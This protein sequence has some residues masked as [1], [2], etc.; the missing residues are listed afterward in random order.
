M[1]LKL[2][3]IDAFTDR[4]FGGNP[5]AVCPLN[6][7]LE[8]RV[9]QAIAEENNLAE[10]AFFLPAKEGYGLRWFTPVT[11]VNLCGHATLA[12]AYV[13]YN[14]LGHRGPTITFDTLSGR[15]TV[16]RKDEMFEMD[17]PSKDPKPCAAPDILAQALGK[18]PVEVLC[19]DNYIAVFG[20]E[21]EVREISPDLPKLSLLDLRGVAVTAKGDES[22]FVSRFFAPKYGIDEDPVTG[23][24]HCE[25]APYWSKKLNKQRLTARQVSKRGGRLVCEVKPPRVI[26]SGTAVKYMEAE[27]E[28]AS[29]G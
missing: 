18:A 12:A 21:G 26:L 25:L 20:T 4:V 11:E 5:A 28:F 15:L 7:W 8:D 2:Y 13:L 14:C 1:K 19:H 24:S 16:T 9:L 17:F 6:E 27:I 3:Q 22:D 10:T 29:G 23:S